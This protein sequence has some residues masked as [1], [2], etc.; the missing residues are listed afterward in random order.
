MPLLEFSCQLQYPSGFRAEPAFVTEAPVTALFG[1]SG[2]GKTSILSMIAGL[3]RPDAGFIRLG[4]RLLFDSRTGAN[5]PPEK[6]RVGYV[7]QDHLLFP[8]L[9]VRGNLLYGWRRRARAAR[10]VDFDK[11]VRVLELADLLKRLPQSLSGG[12]RQRV[13]LGRGLLCGPELLLLDEPLSSVDDELKQR[14]LDYIRRVLEEWRV[15]TLYVTHN[16]AE[17]RQMAGWVVRIDQGRV[18]AAGRPEQVL[19]EV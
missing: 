9:D 1:P 11:V 13:A 6:R 19:T 18:S 12:Q 8:H 10:A 4:A 5:L 3:R 15:P 17:A 7:F 16:P 14:V 2:S